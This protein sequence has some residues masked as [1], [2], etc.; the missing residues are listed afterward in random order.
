MTITV[1]ES[2]YSHFITQSKK[3]IFNDENLVIEVNKKPFSL[4][5]VETDPKVAFNT[6]IAYCKDCS[7]HY[8]VKEITKK[9]LPLSIKKMYKIYK[10]LNS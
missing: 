7:E 4:S 3:F 9:D 10:E 1:I 8:E 5:I 6:E 2:T